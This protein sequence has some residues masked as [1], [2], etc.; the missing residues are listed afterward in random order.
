[1]VGIV[2][3]V[4][5]VSFEVCLN[6]VVSLLTIGSGNSNLEQENSWLL[7]SKYFM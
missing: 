2:N 4:I 1:M 7:N 6:E 3:V 5:R